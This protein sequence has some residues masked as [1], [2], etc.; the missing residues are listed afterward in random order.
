MFIRLGFTLQSDAKIT[1]LGG[2]YTYFPRD[3]TV[4]RLVIN[5]CLYLYGYFFILGYLIPNGI[6][7]DTDNFESY[8]IMLFCE[9]GTL[10][11]RI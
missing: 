6:V 11:P 9:E 10:K 1:G 4:P 3:F 8:M 5:V 2:R 7:V